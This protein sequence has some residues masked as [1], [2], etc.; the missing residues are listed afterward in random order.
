LDKSLKGT[1]AA[2]NTEVFLTSIYS[3][4]G[5]K[6]QFVY[7]PSKRGLKVVNN[8]EIDAEAV[9]INIVGDTYSN[10]IRIDVP[11]GNATVGFFCLS[12]ELCK[13]D[14]SSSIAVLDGFEGG[15]ALCSM[16]GLNCRYVSEPMNVAKMLKKGLVDA[17]FATTTEARK[18]VCI[19]DSSTVF[20]ALE[21]KLTLGAYHYVHRKHI[22]LKKELEAAI[23]L[24]K[25]RL[26]SSGEPTVEQQTAYGCTTSVNVL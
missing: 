1:T 13:V 11:L 20:F 17:L 25:K 23:S 2:K 21:K 6:P 12:K 3:P 8:G 19:I 15:R 7:Y 4:L 26:I 5:I 24:H 18:V 22:G 9:R 10:L 16:L 14:S